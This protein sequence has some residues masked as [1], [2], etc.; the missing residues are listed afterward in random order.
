MAAP[1]QNI[2]MNIPG[3][4]NNANMAVDNNN[5][6]DPAYFDDQFEQAAMH[7]E[8]GDYM[9]LLN[10]LC[11]IKQEI[12][13]M[14]EY[15]NEGAARDRMEEEFTEGMDELF[16]Q[17]GGRRRKSRRAARKSRRAARKSRRAARKSR[18]SQRKARK[19]RR[20]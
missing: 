20:R 5:Y 11:Q 10:V 6:N 18:K 4:N 14:G 7:K 12:E 3:R 9:S 13:N 19:T 1:N 16:G 8:N 2:V 15:G 17:A